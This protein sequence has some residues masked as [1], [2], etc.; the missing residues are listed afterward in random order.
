LARDHGA[1]VTALTISP[2]QHSYA[3]GL[4]PGATNPVYL[5]RDWQQNGLP[6]ESFDVVISI[7]SS[8]HM[9]DKAVFFSEVARVL[10]PGGRFVVCAWLSKA[11]PHAWEVNHLLEP[12]CREGRLPGMGTAEEYQQFARDAGLEPTRFEDV[13]RQVK[14][15]WPLCAWRTIKGLVRKP[16][17]RRFLFKEKS[18]DRI[19][20][21]TLFRIWLAYE[22]GSMRYGVL[23][24]LKPVTSVLHGHESRSVALGSNASS[25][26]QPGA[27]RR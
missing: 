18:P 10:K 13:S 21:L 26:T 20:A 27:E 7:E 2:A 1:E 14:R 9:L 15:T 17:Y 12:I 5:L 16:S 22:T 24:A 6:S 19:F 25:T 4:Q 3:S 23:S 8:E 11:S